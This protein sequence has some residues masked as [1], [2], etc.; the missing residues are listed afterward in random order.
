MKI[1]KGLASL[2]L[3]LVLVI[4]IPAVL[5][6]IV[7]NP[8]PSGETLQNLLTTPDYGGRFLFGS[9]LPIVAWIAW[10]TFAASVIVEVPS[11]VGGIR[12]PRI[13]G[14]GAQQ[15]LA[16]ALIGAILLMFTAGSLIS[17]PKAQATAPE[18]S[19]TQISAPVSIE[20]N[21]Q[22]KAQA[23]NQTPEQTKALPK[24]TV[25]AGESLWL[26]AETYLGDGARYSEIA[27][28][29]YGVAQA[30][31]GALSDG[32]WIEPGWV[33][34]LPASAQV[35]E[36][37]A[38]THVVAEGESLSSIAEHYYGDAGAFEQ[39]FKAS[40]GVAQP[41]GGSLTDP[42]VVLPGW[43][44]TVPAAAV[45]APASA[46]QAA[47]PPAV[48]AEVPPP[49]A[50]PAPAPVEVPA[51]AVEAPAAPVAGRRDPCAD[52][53]ERGSASACRGASPRCGVPHPGGVVVQRP[54]CSR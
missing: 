35:I 12:A 1:V 47:T 21:T 25:V 2:V 14:L 29:N 34:N 19:A 54:C 8:L 16:G 51:P 45:V 18:P 9:F 44:L 5:V 24:H 36:K 52:S 46:A 11:A 23:L 4:G 39:I 32:H 53:P 3:L 7:G 20:A 10:L 43:V 48:A 42:D 41:G 40:Q 49:E 6:L 17:A 15:A 33:L 27:E 31:G 38:T 50:A 22:N 28:L 13:K 30:D 26:L 37:Q